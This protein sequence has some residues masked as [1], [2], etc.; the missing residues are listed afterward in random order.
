[1]S[2]PPLGSA[3]YD[4]TSSADEVPHKWFLEH[5]LDSAGGLLSLSLSQGLLSLSLSQRLL[6]LPLS[7]ILL[8]LSLSQRLL[9]LS[10]SQGCPSCVSASMEECVTPRDAL[11]AAP[12]ATGGD[13]VST[14][15]VPGAVCTGDTVRSQAG[16]SVLQNTPGTTVRQVREYSG[17]HLSDR[18]PAFNTL[19]LDSNPDVPVNSSL[20]DCKNDA[21]DHEPTEAGFSQSPE[22]K[23][24]IRV[25]TL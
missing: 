8:S 3:V 18:Q 16:A 4:I 14:R 6:S 12:R 22:R 19:K 24:E 23:D 5:S 1:M 13:V 7:Q 9:S 17:D 2:T 25:V 11:V 10:L 20:F 15:P 21:L